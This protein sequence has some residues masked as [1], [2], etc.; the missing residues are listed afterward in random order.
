[1]S[2]AAGLRPASGKVDSRADTRPPFPWQCGLVSARL[3]TFLPREARHGGQHAARARRGVFSVR[4]RGLCVSVF[5]FFCVLFLAAASA[6][7]Q[8]RV[9][10]VVKDTDGRP[11]KGATIVAESPNYSATVTTVTSDAKGRYSFLGLRARRL[12]LH[13]E[14]AGLP[15]VAARVRRRGRWA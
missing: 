8:G 5:I 7:A 9:T 11:I 13:R 14:R 10:G 1:M 12:D 4:L 3:S 15:A 6:S 2:A